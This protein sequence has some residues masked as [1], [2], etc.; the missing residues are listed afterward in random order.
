MKRTFVDLM[1]VLCLG[2]LLM[3]S[4]V[5][6]AQCNDYSEETPVGSALQI[7]HATDSIG[8]IY[9]QIVT[10]YA[11]YLSMANGERVKIYSNSSLAWAVDYGG[12]GYAMAL[13]TDSS[14][15]IVG[16]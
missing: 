13:S 12:N 2:L 1:K 9:E 4:S 5:R 6:A 16:S 7:S 14:Y 15:L 11:I 8:S 3:A 10:T